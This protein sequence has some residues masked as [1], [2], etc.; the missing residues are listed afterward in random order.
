LL[1]RV[2]APSKD[3]M[4]TCLNHVAKKERFTLPDEAA[5]QIIDD[6]KGNLRKA[7]LVLEALKVQSPDLSGPLSIAK[8]DWETYCHKLADMIVQE[9]SP[10]RVMEVRA[11]F[12]ELLA[13]CI[14][15]TTILKTVAERVIERVDEALRADI[16]HW[17]AF[18]EVRMRLG[19][20]KIFH[21]EAWV[22][23]VMTLYKHFFYDVDLSAFDE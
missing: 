8:P 18:Y 22:I 21:L 4:R 16:I 1:V 20:K 5:N 7:I 13:H 14:P 10:A 17:A 23:K 12:Y 3:E 19:S 15:P 6:A 11:K 9:Q 2:A